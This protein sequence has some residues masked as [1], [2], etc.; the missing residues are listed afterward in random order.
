MKVNNLSGLAILL[1]V[2]VSACT[3]EGDPG[4]DPMPSQTISV[5]ANTQTEPG[6]KS[7]LSGLAT[8]W[9]AGTDKIGVFSP[10]AKTTQSGSTP[11]NNV[12]FTAQRSATSSAFT[13]TMYWGNTSAAHS[14]Y[15]YYPCNSEYTGD[16]T[17]VPVALSASQTQTQADNNDDIGA[18]DF[19][20]AT[21]VTVTSPSVAGEI[22]E[23]VNL[24]FQHV[25]SL[26]ELQIKGSGSLSQVRLTGT[27][28]LS[29]SSGTI[30]LTQTPGTDAYTITKSGTSNDV[31]VTLGTPVPLSS[32]TAV[33]IYM[34]VLPGT[35][36]T[37]VTISVKI[38]EAWKETT[39]TLSTGSFVRGK[40]YVFALN[41]DD[42]F[43]LFTD[44]RDGNSYPYVT[45]GTQVWMAENLAYLPAVS[46]ASQGSTIASYYYVYNYSGSDVATAKATGNYG[47]YGVLYN[48]PAA[49]NGSSS[50]GSN[51][52]GVQ[53][54][55]PA[56]WHLPSAA[57]WTQLVNTL[58]GSDVAGGKMKETGTAHWSSPNTDATNESGFTALGG[59]YRFIWYSN[60]TFG[61]ITEAGCFWS[62]TETGTN[63]YKENFYNSSSYA[64]QDGSGR[65]NGFSVRCIKD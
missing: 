27:E 26:V 13:G 61:G 36:S 59:G 18:L 57:E 8:Y 46:P 48:W 50:S 45:I 51:P 34:M 42:I 62:S 10:Q 17:G 28:P 11:A 52:S 35:H 16:Q 5:L 63:A 54:I 58:G 37:G 12:A 2:V 32:E 55:C 44:L 47:T 29:F 33:S 40:K 65:E 24:N 1:V 7:T 56:G 19:L 21:P 4:L 31:S 25:F 6:T 23:S 39:K 20:A 53:G 30:D 60:G 43:N 41:A 3:K 22:G 14:F 9:V 38:G 49:M 15:A 64:T